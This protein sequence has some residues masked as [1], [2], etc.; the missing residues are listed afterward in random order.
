MSISIH[1]IF[2]SR[3]NVLEIFEEQGYDISKYQRFSHN[4]ISVMF[5]HDGLDMFIEPI[6]STNNN[7]IIEQTNESNTNPN[8]NPNTIT[9]TNKIYIRYY[10]KK[11]FRSANIQ[12]MIDNLFIA[13]EKLTK[14]DTLYII[15]K[16]EP[17]DTIRDQLKHIWEK[18][19]IFI[20]VQNIKRLQFNIMK[21]VQV[22]KQRIITDDEKTQMLKKYNIT[23]L[24]ELPEISRFEPVAQALCLR[25]G[26]ISISLRPSKTSITVDWYR[27]CI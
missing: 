24:N 9:K 27:L 13:E 18:D 12:E 15:I 4:E 11:T 25:P 23:D 6:D 19:E 20:V 8:T 2:K 1:Q 3:N 7:T 5:E 21:L 26:M 10:L 16:D 14:H 17:N 22:P